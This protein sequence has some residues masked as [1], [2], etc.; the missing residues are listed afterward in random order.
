MASWDPTH[1]NQFEIS[2]MAICGAC[3]ETV[4]LGPVF[5][6]PYFLA[7]CLY[8]VYLAGLAIYR[9]YFSPIAKFPGSKLTAVSG[10]YETYFQF[11]KRGGGQFTFK[12][13]EWHDE[14]GK[15]VSL[16]S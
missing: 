2:K 8:V 1:C 9:L 11:V 7:V 14:Y 13:K 6:S 10:W 16:P 15:V 4:L 12:I 5:S 3:V